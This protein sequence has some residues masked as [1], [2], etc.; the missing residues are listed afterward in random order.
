EN[1][2]D[3]GGVFLPS[4]Q[5]CPWGSRVLEEL[6]NETVIVTEAPSEVNSTEAPTEDEEEDEWVDFLVLDRAVNE[7]F[8][9]RM[10]NPIVIDIARGELEK[11]DGYMIVAGTIA[12]E[13]AEWNP[14]WSFH[15]MPG[16]MSLGKYFLRSAM[17]MWNTWKRIL[18]MLVA[19]FCPT[20]SGAPGLSVLLLPLHPSCLEYS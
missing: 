18:Q 10:F 8:V 1:L 3:A 4:L 13:P 6:G 17:P 5:L 9:A 14:G 12:K 15:M 20:I 7:T 16:S 11:E 2:A 19:H